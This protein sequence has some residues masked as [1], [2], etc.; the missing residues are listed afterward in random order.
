MGSLEQF[1][2]KETGIDHDSILAYLSDG[3]RLRND[4]VRELAGVQ[5]QVGYYILNS[6]V[7]RRDSYFAIPVDNIHV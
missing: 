3:T 1:L 6:K 2:S 5:D 4:N 7:R